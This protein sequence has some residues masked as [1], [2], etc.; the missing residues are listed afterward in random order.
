ML[1][2]CCHPEKTCSAGFCAWATVGCDVALMTHGR[3]TG[4]DPLNSGLYLLKID[5][6]RNGRLRDLAD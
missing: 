5:R 6:S 3:S 2:Q 4:S 1:C